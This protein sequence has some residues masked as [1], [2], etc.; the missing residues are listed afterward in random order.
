MLPDERLELARRLWGWEAHSG[1]RELLTLRLPD[2]S[3][4]GVLVAA[5][6][7]RWGKTEALGMDT[8]VRL[9]IEPDLGQ[10]LVAPTKDQADTLFDAVEEKLLSVP[11]E[12]TGAFP[13]LQDLSIKRSPYCHIRRKSDG[14]VILAARTA[15]VNGRNLRGKGTTRRVKRFRVVV[16][17]AAFVPDA[18]IREAIFPML[19]TVPGGGQ[20]AMISSPSGRRGV[21][22][23]AFCRGER[24]DG[25]YRSVRLPS[26]QNPL[27]DA[28]FLEEMRQTMTERQFRAE[29]LA[30]F[31]ESEGAVFAESEILAAVC[32]DDYGQCPLYGMRYVAGIDLARRTDYTV[33]CILEAGAHGA[34][35]VRLCR[36]KGLPWAEQV[37]RVAEELA[38]WEVGVAVCDATGM[39]DPVTEALATEILR[40]RLRCAVEPFTFTLASK[41]ALVDA[42]TMALS[43]GRLRFPPY[44]DLLSELRNFEIRNRRAEA[45]TG[46]DDCV[47]A[48]GLGVHA[49]APYLAQS[50]VPLFIGATAG[51][52]L[53]LPSDTEQ[54]G[55]YT[56]SWAFYKNWQDSPDTN[57]NLPRQ[58]LP[59]LLR[60]LYSLPQG[61]SAGAFLRDRLRGRRTTTT[62]RAG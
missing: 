52:R 51:S 45:V 24:G 23:E 58:P 8:A 26:C 28:G 46:H 50:V 22:Y 33:V 1:Q 9:L 36:W 14:A 19:A 49:A 54:K 35:V 41:T 2:G 10:L 25:R 57:R 53:P 39:G 11:E 27:V 48:L 7:R 43:Q 3:E 29:F 44:P 34:R 38:Q 60:C 5:C 13:V 30:E 32:A 40:R 56:F 55:R 15:G 59:T 61:R 18:A 42:L 17:E 47:M 12:A 6:G 62:R 20:L 16:D 31:I 4:P 21:F 37:R